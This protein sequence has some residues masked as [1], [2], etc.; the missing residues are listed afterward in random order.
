MRILVTGATGLIGFNIVQELLSRNHEVRV[1]A[2]T[3]DKA[4]KLFA[5]RCEVLRGDVTEP[6]SIAPAAAGCE[7]VFHAAGF[8]EQWMKDPAIFQ[9][10][11]VGG[12]KN[13]LE[14]CKAAGVRRVAYTSTID[15]FAGK[16]G[17]TYNESVLDPKPKGT[18]YERSK[19]DADKLAVEFQRGGMDIVF[20][21]PSGLYGPGPAGSPG[22]NQ[23]IVDLK[24]GKIPMLLPGGLPV[25]Y[26]EDVARGHVLA[27]E[28]GKSGDRFILS[29]SYQTLTDVATVICSQ[30]GISKLPPVMPLWMGRAISAAGEALSSLTGKPPLIPRGQLHFL[31]WQ[32]VPDASRAMRELGWQPVKFEEGIRRTIAHLRAEGSL[33]Q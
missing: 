17:E 28:K 21:H 20:L 8:P 33:P 11:N 19:Q 32:A 9:Q 13:V 7:L 18:Y 6:A 2:R 31:Q 24:K 3:P 25:V 22:M 10:V 30:L 27:A 5:N 12:T 23:I 4:K 26:S 29:E 1:L 16:A 15:V 14:A